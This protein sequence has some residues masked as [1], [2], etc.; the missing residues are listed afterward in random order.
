MKKVYL[1]TTLIVLVACAE[2]KT[3][4]VDKPILVTKN[5]TVTQVEDS[6]VITCPDGTSITLPPNVVIQ[7]ETVEIPV[8][9]E[10]PGDCHDDNGN[11]NGHDHD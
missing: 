7:T 8:I 10:V 4:L 9:V 1:I 2:S 6:A 3:K 5:C 11:H